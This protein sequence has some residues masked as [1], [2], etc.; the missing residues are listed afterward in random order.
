MEKITTEEKLKVDSNFKE[1]GLCNPFLFATVKEEMTR[2]EY[3][4]DNSGFNQSSR[5]T[6]L[7]ISDQEAKELSDFMGFWNGSRVLKSLNY[8]QARVFGCSHR[9][10]I[11]YMLKVS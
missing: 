3:I 7:P 9:E 4:C 8:A 10:S 5:S 6:H 1:I 2:I 11:Y